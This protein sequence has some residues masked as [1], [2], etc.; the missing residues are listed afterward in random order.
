MTTGLQFTEEA[1]EDINDAF[2]WYENK[3]PGLGSDFLVELELLIE[4]IQNSP[5]RFPI[6]YKNKRRLLFRKFSAYG[7][8][9]EIHDEAVFVTAIAH[10]SQ[11]PRKWQR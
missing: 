10:S 3:Q 5:E 4:R 9:Y 7:V 1:L 2:R 8:I 6:V 11:D